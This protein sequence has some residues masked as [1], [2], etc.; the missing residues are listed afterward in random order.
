MTPIPELPY[1]LLWGERV[2]R[3]VAN[4]TRTDGHEF[5]NLA[6]RFRIQT[7]VQEFALEEANEALEK[8]K[9]G[10]LEGTAVLV[11]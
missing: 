7:T 10:R 8:M 3:S 5:M 2:L 11:P 9:S 1:E 6:P 4:M